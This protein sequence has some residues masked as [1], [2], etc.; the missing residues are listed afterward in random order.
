[1]AEVWKNAADAALETMNVTMASADAN[2]KAR[3]Q[4]GGDQV[5]GE[6]IDGVRPKEKKRARWGDGDADEEG[7]FTSSHFVVAF[8]ESTISQK[9]GAPYVV[10]E[11]RPGPKC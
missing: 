8:F 9:P 5:E 10:Y 4:I 7:H 6:E 3:H 2:G 11:A 1:M